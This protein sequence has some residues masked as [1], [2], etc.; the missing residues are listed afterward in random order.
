MEH[1]VVDATNIPDAAADDELVLLGRQGGETISGAELARAAGL[2]ELELL[3][4]LAR[5]F[6]RRYLKGPHHAG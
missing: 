1:L 2:S 6:P 3:P 4:R 5:S